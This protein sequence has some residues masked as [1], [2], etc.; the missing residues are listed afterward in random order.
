MEENGDLFTLVVRDIEPKDL[1]NYSC[2]A[3]NKIGEA[4]GTVRLTGK[5]HKPKKKKLVSTISFCICFPQ[6]SRC[7]P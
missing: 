5:S 6:A 2:L 7:K 1:G 3:I 4:Q